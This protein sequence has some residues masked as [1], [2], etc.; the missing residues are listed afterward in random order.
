MP[1]RLD[2]RDVVPPGVAAVRLGSVDVVTKPPKPVPAAWVAHTSQFFTEYGVLHFA[3]DTPHDGGSIVTRYELVAEGETAVTVGTGFKN[4]RLVS[5]ARRLSSGNVALFP[6]FTAST[7]T[8]TVV[9]INA[10]G[11]SEPSDSFTLDS[12]PGG[13]AVRGVSRISSFRVVVPG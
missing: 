6:N 7:A 8:L 5:L 12:L 11:E 3:N 10:L 1:L 13:T 9:A 2:N 4:G